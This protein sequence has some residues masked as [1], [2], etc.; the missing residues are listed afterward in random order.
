M[1]ELSIALAVIAILLTGVWAAGSGFLSATRAQ[2]TGGDLAGLT[3]ATADALLRGVK[4]TGQPVFRTNFQDRT[5]FD[6][7]WGRDGS[8]L[9]SE[10]QPRCFDLSIRSGLGW[11]GAHPPPTELADVLGRFSG[12][13][14]FGSAPYVVCLTGKMVQ[15]ATCVPAW[16]EQDTLALRGSGCPGDDGLPGPRS[17]ACPVIGERC[18]RMARSLFPRHSLGVATTYRHLYLGEATQP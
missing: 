5:E 13:N 11:G 15:A 4:G 17:G 18:V 10:T 8:V 1:I 14:A 7:R 12:G 9:F 3:E 2:R 16:V 6:V